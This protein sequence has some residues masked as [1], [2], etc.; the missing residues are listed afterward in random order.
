MRYNV[1]VWFG[2]HTNIFYVIDGNAPA[3]EQP[4][5]IG[6]FEGEQEMFELAHLSAQALNEG[7]TLFFVGV[8]RHAKTM[9][10]HIKHRER[11]VTQSIVSPELGTRLLAKLC[12]RHPLA[13]V[14]HVI[15]LPGY[16]NHKVYHGDMLDVLAAQTNEGVS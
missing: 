7:A 3:A 4:N 6:T 14:D 8:E 11:P 13:V 16:H 10:F 15:A 1:T 2:E 12:A 9:L 5:V